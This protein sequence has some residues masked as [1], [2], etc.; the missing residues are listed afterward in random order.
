M[1]DWP[2]NGSVCNYEYCNHLNDWCA[3]CAL[4]LWRCQPKQQTVVV[5]RESKGPFSFK[6]YLRDSFRLQFSQDVQSLWKTDCSTWLSDKCFK[7]PWRMDGQTPHEW[8]VWMTTDPDWTTI[9]RHMQPQAVM[10]KT[11]IHH[12]SLKSQ[13]NSGDKAELKGLVN[14]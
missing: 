2:G 4:V 11:V 14:K 8:R 12:Q 9:K 13:C 1:I 10:H 5:A 6:S 7:G 3:C